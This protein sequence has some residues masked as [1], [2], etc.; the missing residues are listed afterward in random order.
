[1]RQILIALLL[2]GMTTG[3]TAQKGTERKELRE[4]LD[5][6]K[7]AY[8]NEKAELT[9]NESSKYWAMEAKIKEETK[10]VKKSSR[11]LKKIDLAELSDKEADSF[12][13]AQLANQQKILDIK[14]KYHVDL[15]SAVGAKKL[16][17]IKKANR[18]F[19]REVLKDYRSEKQEFKNHKRDNK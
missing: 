19:K 9:E 16:I 3:L 6:K 12:L 18:D 15:V 10:A 17:A 1:M 13:N 2:I 7:V 14:K 4:K 11:S 5:A 8:I